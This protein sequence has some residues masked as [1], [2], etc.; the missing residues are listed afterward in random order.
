MPLRCAAPRAITAEEERGREGRRQAGGRASG[1]VRWKLFGGGKVKKEEERQR[2]RMKSRSL[3]GEQR[4][5]HFLLCRANPA[6]RLIVLL[7]SGNNSSTG[8]VK[9]RR[10]R[11]GLLR[12]RS[13]CRETSD[14]HAGRGGG[15]LM[16]FFVY[17][18]ENRVKKKDTLLIWKLSF[19]NKGYF[20]TP[21]P[22]SK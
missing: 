16:T 13:V 7:L 5:S 22:V 9:L 1:P 17:A 11:G 20:W 2:E 3:S 12:G 8:L 21:P 18:V 19:Q 15:V 4:R 14:T 10:G 6:A